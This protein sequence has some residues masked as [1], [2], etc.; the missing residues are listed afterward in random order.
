MDNVNY[1]LGGGTSDQC[2][3]AHVQIN[4]VIRSDV[5]QGR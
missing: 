2:I 4:T 3:V 5:T 1:I